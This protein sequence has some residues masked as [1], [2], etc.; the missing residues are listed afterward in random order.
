MHH[1]PPD[2]IE[3]YT[4]MIDSHTTIGSIPVNY[5]QRYTASRH[6]LLVVYSTSG[7]TLNAR[8]LDNGVRAINSIALSPFLQ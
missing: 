1:L 2:N 5:Y 4:R 8:L 6:K 7:V 3:S